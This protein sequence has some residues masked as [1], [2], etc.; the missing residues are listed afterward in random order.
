[1]LSVLNLHTS[2][3]K[4]DDIRYTANSAGR[5]IPFS[6]FV[7]FDGSFRFCFVVFYQ[8]YIIVYCCKCDRQSTTVI[9][10]E[11][12]KVQCFVFHVQ[13]SAIKKIA[14][15]ECSRDGVSLC[16]VP[17]DLTFVGLTSRKNVSSKI[18]HLAD[19]NQPAQLQKLARILKLWI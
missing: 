18:F 12:I 5:L 4:I 8:R 3:H 1:M 9:I 15:M 16:G 14:E 17:Q 19:A 6:T 13:T 11:N 2:I 7:L 10:F